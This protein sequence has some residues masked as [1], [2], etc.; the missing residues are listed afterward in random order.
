MA[1]AVSI[2]ALGSLSADPGIIISTLDSVVSWV[3]GDLSLAVL[4]KSALGYSMM[5]LI[6]LAL[7]AVIIRSWLKMYGPVLQST[8]GCV[9]MAAEATLVVRDLKAPL[10]AD[11][12]ARV[13][14]QFRL[15]NM[16][17]ALRESQIPI[18][19]DLGAGALPLAQAK[20]RLEHDGQHSWLIN[21]VNYV[22]PPMKAQ[23]EELLMQHTRKETLCWFRSDLSVSA[24]LDESNFD[25]AHALSVMVFEGCPFAG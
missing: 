6:S 8:D 9:H 5:S 19:I 18:K 7:W 11:L 20:S 21:I 12:L 25:A 15:W 13:E 14:T 22:D 10:P 24:V 4:E 3:R 1:G 17:S 2:V 23:L 16:L